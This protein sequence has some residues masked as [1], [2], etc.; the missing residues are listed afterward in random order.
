M[1]I[2]S[3]DTSCTGTIME[4]SEEIMQEPVTSQ[5]LKATFMLAQFPI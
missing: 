2:D 1:L 3:N 5:R 4:K